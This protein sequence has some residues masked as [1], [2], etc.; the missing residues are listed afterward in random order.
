MD[1]WDFVDWVE[2]NPVLGYDAETTG[3]NWWDRDR[4]FRCRPAQF[5]NAT[6]SWVLP[7]EIDPEFAE[8]AAWALRT[9]HR[10]I[11][12]NANFDAHVAEV[13][14]G[15]TLEELAPRLLCT[16]ISAHLVDPRAVKEQGPG[17]KLEELT[18]HY[19]SA[20]LATGVKRSTTRI[21]QRYSSDDSSWVRNGSGRR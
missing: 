5:G 12:H 6:E 14:L 13:T 16:K 10:V 15:V 3:L 17:L 20:D 7:V 9:A 18:K 19:I 8:A 11:A 21:A 2:V 1:L 4:D